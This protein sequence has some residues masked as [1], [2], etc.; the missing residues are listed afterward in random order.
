MI[1]EPIPLLSLSDVYYEASGKQ[2]IKEFSCQ[3]KTGPRN[4]IIG[5]NGAGKSL[6]LKLCHRLL[7]PSQG[8][9]QWH[10]QTN[11]KSSV[12][13]DQAMVFQRPVM[14]RRTAAENIDYAL[15]LRGLNK[16]QRN[17]RTEEV[18]ES[19]GLTPLAHCSARV[20]SFGEQQKLALARAWALK[21]KI[22][23]LDEPTASLD[24]AATFEI[25]KVINA[26]HNSGTEIIMTTHDLPQARRL[27]DEVIFIHQGKLL[28]SSSA[29]SFFK[30]PKNPYAQAFLNGDLLLWNQTEIKT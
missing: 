9:I 29:T 8:Y 25:E 13:F 11:D 28:E 10:G 4:I 21:P 12:I 18:L 19:T 15:S 27:A 22:L 3:F 5:P 30:R 26:I 16:A 24:P 17:A 23:F 20:L 14:L 6:L 7:K 2:L 1:T